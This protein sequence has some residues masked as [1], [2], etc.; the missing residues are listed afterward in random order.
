MGGRRRWLTR[1]L[2]REGK[3]VAA[4]RSARDASRRAVN[5]RARIE[6]RRDRH[7]ED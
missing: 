2:R 6:A 7:E 3:A 4:E 1:D 5:R